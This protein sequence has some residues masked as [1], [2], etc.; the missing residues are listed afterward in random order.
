MSFEHLT[1]YGWNAEFAAH[2]QPFA[3]EG[4]HPGRVV[5][6]YNQFYRVFTNEGEILA[7]TTGKL[8]H[9]AQSRAD[10]PAVGDWVALKKR[11]D[12]PRARIHAILPRRSK[13]TRK[14][15]GAKTEEQVVGAN[16]DTILLVTSLN[17]DFNPRRM[18]RYLTV[19]VNSGVK[20][21][22]LLS[23]ADL[24]ADVAS[25]VAAMEAVSNGAPVHAI[26]A[27]HGQGVAEVQAY[28]APGQTIAIVGTSGVGKSTLINRLLGIDRQ[29]ISEV[30][31]S[32]ERGQHTTRHR[33]LILLPQGGLVLDT[34]GMRELQLWEGDEGIEQVF[35]DV[36]ALALQCRFS[37]CGHG[38]EPGCAI[39]AAIADGTLT[40]SRLE[41]Y[42]KMLQ[43]LAHLTKRQQSY[44]QLNEQKQKMKKLARAGEER[45]RAKRRGNE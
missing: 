8:R 23:K 12:Q 32:D 41:N 25:K 13:F 6:E 33:E 26:S 9:E 43:E 15:A 2:F 38:R 24:C 37:N 35:T 40:R 17:Q 21:V 45:G 5:L 1:S 20:P 4:C 14:T 29:K 34:P 22:V 3:E 31:E 44:A 10:L 7:E 18:E 28:F 27:K 39:R 30:R 11:P 36:E 42:Q 19:A 16:I